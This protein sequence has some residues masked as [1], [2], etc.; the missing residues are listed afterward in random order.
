MVSLLRPCF[1]ALATTL[2]L[3]ACLDV[4]EE[5][6]RVDARVGSA[7]VSGL[8]VRVGEG[9]AAVRE[10]TQDSLTLWVSAP[11]LD[12]RMQS[13]APSTLRLRIQNA[14]PDGVLV[15]SAAPEPVAELERTAATDV[16][17]SVELAEGETTLRFAVPDADTTEPFRYGVFADV[18]EAIDSVQDLYRAMNE[19]AQLRFVVM[20]GD[21]TEQGT[22]AQ[23]RRFERE[24]RGLQ[25]PCFSTLGNH[26][27]GASEDNYHRFFGRGSRHFEFKGAHFTLLD[28]ASATI[29]PQAYEWLDGWLRDGRAD[30][31]SL[32]MHL[33]ALDSSGLRNG[34]PRGGRSVV[35]EAGPRR[36]GPYDLRSCSHL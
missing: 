9:A 36:S 13:Q 24:L 21:L 25:V 16:V 32:Y 22:N 27:L 15:S 17:Y 33:P 31:H 23:L 14:M 29:A 6:A 5:R 8:S 11:S 2:S 34:Q 28:D 20:S 12:I 4:A 35:V 19:V 10:L 3:G 1:V 18:Q 7:E 26:E 30:F